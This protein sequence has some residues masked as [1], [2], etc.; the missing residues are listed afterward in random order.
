[1]IK[2]SKTKKLNA[3]SWSLQALTTCPASKDKDGE[4]VAACK[5]CYATTG[6]YIRFD[7]VIEPRKHNQK[8]W[9]RSEWVADMVQELDSDRYFRWFDSGDM[10]TLGLANKML[11]VMKATPHC[12]HW[13]PTRMHK[14]SK[15]ADVIA[16]MEALPNVV[17]RLSSD[18]VRGKTIEGEHTSTIIPTPADA[19]V[20]ATVCETYANNG[21]C[22]GCRACWSKDV[23]TIAYPAHGVKMG[24]VIRLQLE[25]MA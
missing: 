12:N 14:F 22:N 19:P 11:E 23:K 1:M 2:L 3:R 13:L 10:Y 16:K 25:V 5:G 17:V 9:K 7:N 18:S 6:N 24:K 20:G 4:L 21:N 8:D 15:F